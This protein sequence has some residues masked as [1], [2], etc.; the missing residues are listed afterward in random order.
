ML[1]QNENL[2]ISSRYS[3]PCIIKAAYASFNKF[4]KGINKIPCYIDKNGLYPIISNR[5]MTVI[6]KKQKYVMLPMSALASSGK[7]F[8]MS[9]NDEYIK[10]YLYEYNSKQ[11]KNVLFKV[12]SFLRDKTIVQFRVVPRVNGE[13]YEIE[14][15]YVSSNSVLKTNNG[16]NIMAIDIGINN[17]AT[18]VI[19]NNK[20][21]IIDGRYLKSI[22]QFYNK[23]KAYLQSMNPNKNV[24]TKME[25]LITEKRKRKMDDVIRKAVGIVVR[26]C[27]KEE[28]GEMI[29]GY[30]PM[31]KQGGVKS[32]APDKLKRTINQ[33]FVQIPIAKFKNKLENSC[34]AR[35]IVFK[36]VGEE[37]TSKCSFYDG[38]EVGKHFFY[39]GKRV[40]RGLF[41]TKKG[42]VVNADVN[43]ALNIL[44]KSKPDRKD[45]IDFLRHRGLT[46]PYRYQI[47][48]H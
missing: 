45:I 43:A 11:I 30:N 19:S 31:F 35:G 40:S 39:K 13:F 41:V 26:E 44:K 16:K 47:N 42:V 28:V 25:Q 2:K 23:R 29:I 27:V 32:K 12:P 18:C 15:S 5:A 38:E 24:Y 22:N 21:F 36:E 48:L 17:L 8:K 9:F 33:N 1:M 34:N 46:I 6:V 37:Y 7:I 4:V 14:F 20:S 3:A 10:K